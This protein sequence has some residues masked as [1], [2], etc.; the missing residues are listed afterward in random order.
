[1]HCGI[2]GKVGASVK[3]TNSHC[4]SAWH[5]PCAIESNY[6]SLNKESFE[7]WCPYHSGRNSR[8]KARES[9]GRPHVQNT[10][11]LKSY[12]VDFCVPSPT[13]PRRYAKQNKKSK[14]GL[15]QS[16]KTSCQ[17]A[18]DIAAT[19]VAVSD[20]VQRPRTDWQR[21]GELWVK[22]VPPWWCDQKTIHFASK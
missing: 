8:S 22:V 17:S 3:C 4:H 2:C 10:H 18:A 9:R 11:Y 19:A 14:T 7:A 13:R 12:H 1:M 20:R 6:I 15:Y 21:H 5:L 16:S